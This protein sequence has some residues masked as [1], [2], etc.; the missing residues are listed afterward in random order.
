MDGDSCAER[1]M[2][3]PWCRSHQDGGKGRKITVGIVDGQNRI[4]EIMSY[5]ITWEVLELFA[6][7]TFEE[8]MDSSIANNND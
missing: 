1:R 3:S 7:R 6:W 2:K 4:L 8:K 5:K